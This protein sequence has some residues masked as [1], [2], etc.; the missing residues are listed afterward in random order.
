MVM[1]FFDIAAAMDV[2]C[3]MTLCLLTSGDP[4]PEPFVRH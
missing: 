2:A 1:G 3:V 4:I